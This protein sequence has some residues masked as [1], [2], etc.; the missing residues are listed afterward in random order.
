MQIYL[1]ALYLSGTY[2]HK[3]GILP[4]SCQLLDNPLY[5]LVL[6]WNSS[7]SFSLSKKIV[8]WCEICKAAFKIISA[9]RV[10]SERVFSDRLFS[11]RL[12]S[13]P[14]FSDHIQLPRPVHRA[15]GFPDMGI[16]TVGIWRTGWGSLIALCRLGK[17]NSVKICSGNW[18]SEKTRGATF[19]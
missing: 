4:P 11:D 8:I 9:P 14:P 19:W 3:T 1:Q 16:Y 10:F 13:D 15:I 5:I 12:F 17:P 7:L 2:C 6:S 18:R